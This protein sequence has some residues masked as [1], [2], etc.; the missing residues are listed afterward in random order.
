MWKKKCEIQRDRGKKSPILQK[1][2]GNKYLIPLIGRK[3]ILRNKP[4]CRK[5]KE[6]RKLSQQKIENFVT[7]SRKTSLSSTIC[8]EEKLTNFIKLPREKN[9]EIRNGI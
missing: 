5:N 9:R 8:R 3:E 2:H 7:R 4:N 6:F 1:N